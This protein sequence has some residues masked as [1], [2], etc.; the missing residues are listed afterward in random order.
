MQNRDVFSIFFRMEVCCVFLLESP[1][2]GDSN[3]YTQ[4]MYII[5]NYKTKRKIT[6]SCPKSAEFE[7]AVVDEPSVF[8]PLKFYNIR[9]REGR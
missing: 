6:L 2:G 3:E 9:N 1:H 7:I 5:F 8:E 4:Y